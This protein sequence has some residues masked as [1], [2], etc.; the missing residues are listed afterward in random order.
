MTYVSINLRL[1]FFLPVRDTARLRAIKVRSTT[2][3]NKTSDDDSGVLG[4]YHHT[5]AKNGTN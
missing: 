4:S 1:T 3:Q 5:S 2:K